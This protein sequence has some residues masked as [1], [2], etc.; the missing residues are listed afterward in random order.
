MTTPMQPVHAQF[1]GQAFATD[2]E[3]TLPERPHLIPELVICPI[4]HD[5]ILFAGAEHTQ[6]LRGR[7]A[8]R[9]LPRL[10]PLLDGTRTLD[11]LQQELPDI[12]PGAV[13]DTLCLL[14]SRGLLED[15]PV[16][17]SR[18]DFPD[19]L[20]FLGRYTDV[21][22]CNRNRDAAFD[23]LAKSAVAVMGPQDFTETVRHQLA[24]AGCPLEPIGPD[25]IGVIISTGDAPVDPATM[26]EVVNASRAVLPVRLG[27][28]EAH[29]GPLLVDNV[30]V[31]AGCV[32]AVHAHPP[33]RPD[34]LPTQLWLSLATQQLLL[35]ITR[36]S[37]SILHRGFHRCTI[38][39]DGVM[40]QDSQLT[41]RIPG[42]ERCGI[43]G[44]PWHPDDPR[45]LAW[46]YHTSAS[47]PRREVITL[48]EH[49][50]HYKAANVNLA[51]ARHELLV[52][53]RIALPEPAALPGPLSWGANTDAPCAPL[54]LRELATVLGRS[55]GESGEGMW[56]RRLAPTGGNLGS[57][58]LWVLARD[59]IGLNRGAYL[60]EPYDHSL[61]FRA[62]FNDDDLAAHLGTAALPA[63]LLLGAADLAKSSQKYHMFAYRLVHFDAGVAL[64]YAHA[65][66]DQ[67][68]LDVR[69]YPNF[70]HDL[71][72]VFDVPQRREF[73]VPTFALGLGA[74]SAPEH[75]TARQL[76]AADAP[77]DYSTYLLPQM[78]AAA[79]HAPAAL[80]SGR[81]APL[82]P[83]TGAA[84]LNALDDVTLARRAV[85]NFAPAPPSGTALRTLVSAADRAIWA[86]ERA[87][88]D[89]ALLRPWLLLSQDTEG[90][91]SGVYAST[92]DGLLRR[93][94][95][96]PSLARECTI[97]LGLAAAPSALVMVA[98]LRTALTRRLVRG[99]C[100]QALYAGTGVAAAWLT[101]TALGLVGTAAGGVIAHGLRCAAG[102]DGFNECPMLAFHVGLP[103]SSL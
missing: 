35:E 60:Y 29:I 71:P 77:P 59:I 79:G 28:R 8:W 67:L 14:F 34:P 27:T 100:D 76:R 102:L 92:P 98:D 9:L 18:P 84:N 12:L 2:A 6:T 4:G 21:S 47:M 56:R 80:R 50:T 57:V 82:E 90:L 42:C 26:T 1:M 22:R 25:A 17:D 55:A 68:R 11:R 5:G 23:R 73:P 86:R 103:T 41:P 30:T 43:D 33:G 48:K 74:R 61:R 93:A 75:E 36:L 87:G 53:E 94:E 96:S 63:C 78:M 69:E 32:A 15:G 39:H 24:A 95:F 101:A 89:A 81:I 83:Q 7:S 99:Y 16:T 65:V 70:T 10:L 66:A 52:G 13:H 45:M 62:P 91:P 85:R 58:R 38:G 97:Q 46:T 54:G 88:A 19:M 3:L 20:S 72:Q 49:Q 31:C 64:A 37:A 51:V 40:S 44:E